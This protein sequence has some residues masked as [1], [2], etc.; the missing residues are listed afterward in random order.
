MY[1]HICFSGCGNWGLGTLNNIF[2]GISVCVHIYIYEK[3]DF[4][5]ENSRERGQWEGVGET[6]R[7]TEAERQSPNLHWYLFD[8]FESMTHINLSIFPKSIETYI[9]CVHYFWEWEKILKYKKAIG[10]L[11]FSMSLKCNLVCLYI[12]A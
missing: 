1:Y 9:Y 4:D 5:S 8:F 12:Y 10:I 6:K 3:G 7:R 11:F 2:R